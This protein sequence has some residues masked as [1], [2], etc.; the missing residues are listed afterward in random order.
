MLRI[1]VRSSPKP[2]GR[3]LNIDA[4]C[5]KPQLSTSRLTSEM[6]FDAAG[7]GTTMADITQPTTS[8]IYARDGPRP[9]GYLGA[10][11][12]NSSDLSKHQCRATVGHLVSNTSYRSSYLPRASQIPQYR[13]AARHGSSFSKSPAKA[14]SLL[15][16]GIGSCPQAWTNPHE[17]PIVS[18]SGRRDGKYPPSPQQSIPRDIPMPVDAFLRRAG[19]GV[20]SG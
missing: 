8:P 7:K 3:V 10:E 9:R 16:S 20:A 5:Q 15:D 18:Q 19:A 13:T 1:H 14:S 12:A 4:G 2:P 6:L 11:E 17:D